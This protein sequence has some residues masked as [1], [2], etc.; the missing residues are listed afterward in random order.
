MIIDEEAAEIVGRIFDLYTEGYSIKGVCHILTESQIPTPTTYKQGL[1]Y[2]Y[3]NPNSNSAAS[4][5]GVWGST[6]VR[7]IL[8]NNTY[9][10]VLTQGKEKK[11]SYKSRKVVK[12]SEDEWVV[13]ENNHEAII[14]KNIF[15]QVQ[16]MLESK[17]TV[18]GDTKGNKN[19]KHI[20]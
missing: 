7:S 17:R 20:A 2:A 14:D 6:T 13:K 9:I 18:S 4:K 16:K 5:L 1:G 12:T 15:Y 8:T 10:G 3:K 19:L 11:L